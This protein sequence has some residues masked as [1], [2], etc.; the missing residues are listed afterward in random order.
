MY[1]KILTNKYSDQIKIATIHS[2][3]VR[4]L[5]TSD[6]NHAPLSPEVSAKRIWSFIQ[7]G[8]DSGIYWDAEKGEELP[9]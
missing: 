4:T 7:A 6:N 5:I 1:G 9:W 3:W 8:F 2:G